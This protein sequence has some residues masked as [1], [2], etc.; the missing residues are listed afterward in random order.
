MSV[1]NKE[2]DCEGCILVDGLSLAAVDGVALGEGDSEGV[3]LGITGFSLGRCGFDSVGISVV[4]GACDTEGSSLGIADV[5]GACDT[6]AVALGSVDT[7]GDWETVRIIL[8]SEDSLGV[9]DTD[10]LR[11]GSADDESLKLEGVA[12]GRLSLWGLNLDG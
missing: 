8:G 4:L 3:A 5:L 2:G 7:L 10:G 11:L 12:L 6:E 9:I 1:G